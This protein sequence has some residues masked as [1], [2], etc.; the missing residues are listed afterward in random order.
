M[1]YIIHI[2]IIL[3]IYIV[4]TTSAN[5][6]VGM[7]NLLSLC[8]AAFFGIGAYITALVLID[9]EMPMIT[10]ILLAM[11]IAGIVGTIIGWLTIKLKG[12]YFVLTTLGFQIIAFTVLYNWTDVTRGPFGISGVPHMTV[13]DSIISMKSLS[14]LTTS[15]LLTMGVLWINYRLIHSP[16]GLAL[17]GVRNDELSML[18]F[19]RNVV[20]IKIQV[21]ALASILTAIAGFIF[22]TYIS[23][24]EPKSFDLDESIFII[25][26]VLIGGTGNLRGPILGAVFVV[27]LPEILR[28][29]ELPDN[30]AANVRM[31]IYGSSLCMF[32]YFRPQGLAGEFKR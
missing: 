14:I 25:S 1:E 32:M 5:L 31:I 21:F 2:L 16:F 7:V 10:A 15:I 24:I 9:L 18:A 12:D 26:A 27:L 11:F 6:V 23:Y 13:M 4:L 22:A 3:N 29:T 20:K 28:F 30:I 17:K 19:G 8:Q